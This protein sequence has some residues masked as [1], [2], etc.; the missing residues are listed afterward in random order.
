MNASD[1][2]TTVLNLLSDKTGYDVNELE[3]NYELEADLGI[4]TVKQAEIFSELRIIFNV[5][6]NIEFEMTTAPTVQSL[7]DWFGNHRVLTAQSEATDVI[8]PLTDS[9]DAIETS[10]EQA[11]STLEDIEATPKTDGLIP[12]LFTTRWVPTPIVQESPIEQPDLESLDSINT[13]DN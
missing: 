8:E 11:T 5:P 12:H 7:I 3:P 9:N 1:T 13:I 2:S 4:D 10:D 6:E